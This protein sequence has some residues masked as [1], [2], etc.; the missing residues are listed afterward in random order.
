MQPLAKK[1]KKELLRNTRGIWHKKQSGFNQVSEVI[2]V[3]LG[4]ALL[5]SVVGWQNLHHFLK[6]YQ[7]TKPNPIM[8]CISP[9]L[10]SAT[11][12][13]SYSDWFIVL[14]TTFV[15]GQSNYFG[16]GFMT[17]NYWKP[18]LYATILLHQLMPLYYF[19][20]LSFLN[21]AIKVAY[22]V[23]VNSLSTCNN[24]TYCKK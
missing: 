4:F 22:L 2:L 20:W 12:N 8:T 24:A 7:E 18:L 23:P 17:L 21:S 3:C 15:I 11:C 5:R 14:F 9:C 19:L 1:K 13:N 6:Q 16:F 10:E